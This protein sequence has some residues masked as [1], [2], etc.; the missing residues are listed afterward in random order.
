MRCLLFAM[1]SVR[2][3]QRLGRGQFGEVFAAVH[4]GNNVAVKRIDRSRLDRAK[5]DAIVSEIALLKGL[6][7]L[8]I[9]NLIDIDW[10]D[11]AVF[12]IMELCS[13]GDFARYLARNGR[14]V[15]PIAVGF[16]AQLGATREYN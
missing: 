5:M 13:G 7:H 6:N 11:A 10:N 2:L 4:R 3:G 14:L 12:I 1:A 16:F 9:V 15:E 8:H